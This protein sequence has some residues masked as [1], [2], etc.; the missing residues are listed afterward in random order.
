MI[1]GAVVIDHRQAALAEP[2]RA[3]TTNSGP[4]AR[5]VTIQLNFA[6]LPDGRI[7]DHLGNVALSTVEAGR[8]LTPMQVLDGQLRHGAPTD[9]DASSEMVA[10]LPQPVT[11]IG[12]TII[13]PPYSGSVALAAWDSQPFPDAKPDAG[14]HMVVGPDRWEMSVWD[15]NAGR[16]VL[17]GGNYPAGKPGTAQSFQVV[18]NGDTAVLT[19]PDGKQHSVTDPR[20]GQWTGSSA[21]WE[22]YETQPGLTPASISALWAT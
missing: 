16:D 10:E 21:T 8:S 19:T 12:A 2:V 3:A 6:A 22:L 11:Q 9:S 7:P 18:R 14:I 13:F 20:V 5:D 1:T 4:A 15:A 17:A